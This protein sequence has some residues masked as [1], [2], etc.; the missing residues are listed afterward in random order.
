MT[1]L[2]VQ[3]NRFLADEQITDPGYRIGFK[4][5]NKKKKPPVNILFISQVLLFFELKEL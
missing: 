3:D 5:K 2:Y 1:N 4:A